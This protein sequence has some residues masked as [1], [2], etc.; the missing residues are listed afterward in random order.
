L[1]FVYISESD[2]VSLRKTIDKYLEWE[3]LAV[4]KQVTLEK[5]IPDSTISGPV[6]FRF[7]DDWYSA[8]ALELYFSF[9]SQN[10]NR[11]QLVINSNKVESR[12]NSFIDY[13]IETLYLDK[14]QVLLFKDG[15][16]EE[17]FTKKL[18]DFEDQKDVDSM[19]N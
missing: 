15:I 19:F 9:L 10:E 14:E 3:A 6:V 16:S 12:T 13:K 11:H 7:G 8:S 2:I 1:S 18:D 4:E 17:A 5:A